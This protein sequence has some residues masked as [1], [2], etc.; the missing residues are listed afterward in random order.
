[1]KF[2]ALIPAGAFV[3][4]VFGCSTTGMTVTT[5][6]KSG[7]LE[8]KQYT[9]YYSVGEWAVPG[10][11]G[12]EVWIDHE[13]KVSPLYPIQLATGTLGPS[14][15]SATGLITVYFVN[16]EQRHRQVTDLVVSRTLRKPESV[17]IGSIELAPRALNKVVLGR[18]PIPNYGTKMDLS[19]Q[20]KLDG[21]PHSTSPTLHRRTV[22]EMQD[23]AKD[24]PW[25]Q[26][27][28]YPFDPPLALP[29]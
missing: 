8:T 2:C 15:L 11:I 12:L 17:Q 3:A 14:D 19:I 24:F 22:T 9:K 20:F 16:L 13:K 27:P 10:Q 7:R 23:P 5:T 18:L 28:Y 25:F 6:D 21:V 1:M 29:K 26:P 4:L